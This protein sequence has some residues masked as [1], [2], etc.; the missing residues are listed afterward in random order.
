MYRSRRK[1][2]SYG[3]YDKKS[4]YIAVE[5]QN[6]ITMD[7]VAEKNYYV[8]DAELRNAAEAY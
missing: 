4:I 6:N 3:S 8:K 1:V 5:D 2:I 7:D